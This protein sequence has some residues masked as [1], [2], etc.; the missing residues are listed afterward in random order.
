VSFLPRPAGQTGTAARAGVFSVQVGFY[1]EASVEEVA[2]LGN[3]A[4]L[5]AVPLGDDQESAFVVL[6]RPI[7]S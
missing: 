6:H 7:P 2:A 1:R 3:Q 5:E 4:G